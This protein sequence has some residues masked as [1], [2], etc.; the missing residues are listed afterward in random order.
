MSAESFEIN[1]FPIQVDASGI[2]LNEANT[3]RK[4]VNVTLDIFGV[5]PQLD[6]LGVT[7]YEI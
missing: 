5:V 2:P 7:R 6:L 3:K 1:A 4:P